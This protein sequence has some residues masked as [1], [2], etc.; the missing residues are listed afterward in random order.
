MA[1]DRPAVRAAIKSCSFAAKISAAPERMAAAA[2]SKAAFFCAV[3]AAA[4]AGKAA[5]AAAPIS[6]TKA[7]AAEAAMDAVGSS[8]LAMFTLPCRAPQVPA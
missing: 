6:A 5:R 4:K 7:V 2:A 3:E 8:L 1:G